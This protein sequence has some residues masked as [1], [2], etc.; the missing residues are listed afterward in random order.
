MNLIILNKR[1]KPNYLSRMGETIYMAGSHVGGA[2]NGV[3][4]GNKHLLSCTWVILN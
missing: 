3:K 1:E 2:G 4:G